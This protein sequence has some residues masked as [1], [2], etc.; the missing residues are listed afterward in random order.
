ME[1][2]LTNLDQVNVRGEYKVATYSRYVLPSLRFHLSVHNIHQC[3]L[4]SLNLMAKKIL[5]RWMDFPRMG[6]CDLSIFHP[7]ILGIKRS[8]QV[9]LEGHLGAQLQSSLLGDRGMQEWRF[10][11]TGRRPRR[12]CRRWYWGRP[13]I[14]QGIW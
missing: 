4:E 11:D 14:S 3:R 12:R 6:A 8:F 7:F 10:L 2:K 1:E 5:R 13:K 9:Y